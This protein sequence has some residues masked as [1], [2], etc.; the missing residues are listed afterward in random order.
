MFR[1]TAA[2]SARND[3]RRGVI[4]L[5]GGV[6]DSRFVDHGKESTTDAWVGGTAK[7]EIV[8]GSILQFGA[9]FVRGTEDRA[10]LQT[11]DTNA[12]PIRFNE[13]RA[14]VGGLAGAHAPAP[15]ASS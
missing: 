12:K 7:L 9:S 5:F 15:A 14:F 1:T 11:P 3:Y 13:A 4:D 10:T 6:S 2:F 8:R